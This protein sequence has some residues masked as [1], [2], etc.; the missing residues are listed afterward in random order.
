MIYHEHKE[1][2]ASAFL[3]DYTNGTHNFGYFDRNTELKNGTKT[4]SIDC[5]TS[6]SRLS[7]IPHRAAL[8]LFILAAPSNISS[9]VILDYKMIKVFLA[10]QKPSLPF[11]IS[12]YQTVTVH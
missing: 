2:L 10:N 9:P 3:A 7:G 11:D 5:I 8:D 12:V 6:R 1:Y 4:P